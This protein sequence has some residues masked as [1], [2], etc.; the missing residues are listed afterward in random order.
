M[1]AHSGAF[2]VLMGGPRGPILARKAHMG[3]KRPFWGP[4]QPL[5]LKLGPT[6]N[7]WSHWVGHIRT[8]CSGPLTALYDTPGAPKTS[9]GAPKGL[10]FGP[11]GCPRSVVDGC[12]GERTHGMYVAHPVV[13]FSDNWA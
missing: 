10:F 11:F 12:K 5:G 3:P 6:V 7:E 2:S 9:E 13:T 1:L 4:G 8:M